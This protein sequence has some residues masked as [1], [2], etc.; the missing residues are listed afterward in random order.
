M[1]KRAIYTALL[2]LLPAH[3]A[4]AGIISAM[5]YTDDAAFSAATGATSLTGPLPELGDVGN[6]VT[7]G[8][9]TLNAGNTIF[10]GEGWSS[11]LPNERA[12]AISG[13]ENLDI[14]IDTGLSTAFGFYF[15]EPA[16]STAKLDGCNASCVDSTFNIQFLLDGVLVDSMSFS[17]VDNKAI[18]EGIILDTAF[19]EVAFT[20][21]TGGIDNEFFG[22]MFVSREVPEPGTLSL[23]A[24]S[25]FGLGVFG[26]R[27]LG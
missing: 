13:N 23:L 12:I 16:G 4:F 21:T 26:R 1:I 9:A 5:E 17:P 24:M 14:S 25:L 10:V 20:E 2:V 19:D 27:R 11:L 22:E 8:D 7:L 15:H 3:A 6:S 18:F